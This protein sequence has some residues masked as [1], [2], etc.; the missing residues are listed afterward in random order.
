[1]F[2]NFEIPANLMPSDPR[3]GVGPSLIP[4]E[5]LERLAATG[6][7]L[8]GTGHRQ[9][10]VI[11]LIKE[12]QE[13]FK[14]YFDLPAG[15]EVLIGNGGAT[16]LFDMIGLGLVQKRSAH[17]VCGEFS[18]KWH[19]AHSLIPWIETEEISVP[20]GQ[21]IDPVRVEGCDTICC[22]LNETSTGVIIKD[23]PDVRGE[24]IL[25]CVDATSGAGQVPID[26]QKVDFYFFSP[27][28]V[29]ASE[30]G[31]YIAFASPKALE[32]ARKILTTNRYIPQIMNFNN[33]IE[34]SLKHQTYNTPAVATIFLLNEQLKLMNKLGR[35]EVE[36]Q[37]NEKAAFIYSWA[38]NHS[39]ISPFIQDPSYRSNTV[40]TIDLDSKVDV[41]EL[42]QM[43]RARN[44]CV[45]IDGYRK[46]G[47]NQLRI[48][49]FHNISLKDLQKL[50]TI[51]ELSLS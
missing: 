45:D 36:R 29:F 20:F 7:S 2:E 24:D 43:L 17:F 35:V 18:S 1:M 8:L 9:L 47:R 11:N 25:V 19:H 50:A 26:L 14:K 30:G 22:T 49:L 6:K 41:K 32:R 16:F 51:V 13:G 33:H 31:L 23:V 15:Y 42:T 21:G 12:V 28:K 48:S 27:Q 3:F 44:A 40:A 38:E 34:F 4:V 10:P 46:L 37:A 5:H 39:L